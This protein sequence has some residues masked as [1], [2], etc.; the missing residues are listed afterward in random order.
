MQLCDC[1]VSLHR[2][3]GFGLTLAAAM[4]HGKPVIATGYSGNL[5]FMDAANSMLV[6]YELV[7]VGPGNDPYPADARWAAPDIDAAAELM[8]RVRREPAH[9]REMGARGRQSVSRTHGLESSARALL[10]HFDRVVDATL[11][12]RVA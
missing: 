7:P 2:S 1:Y 5:A 6:P 8:R 4:A 9:A 10:E 3:E 11:A 12:A